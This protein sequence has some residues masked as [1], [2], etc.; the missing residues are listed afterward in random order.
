M[1]GGQFLPRAEGLRRAGGRGEQEEDP[2]LRGFPD[3]SSSSRRAPGSRPRLRGEGGGERARRRG[4]P[5]CCRDWSGGGPRWS[6][7]G[8]GEGGAR[9]RARGCAPR[10]PAP[11]PRGLRPPHTGVWSR[12][13]RRVAAPGTWRPTHCTPPLSV[14]NVLIPP[15]CSPPSPPPCRR[16][17]PPSLPSSKR[18]RAG[19]AGPGWSSG[20]GRQ[21]RACS[22]GPTEARGREGGDGSAALRRRRSRARDGGGAGSPATPQHLL[23][24]ALLPAA[25]ARAPGAGRRGRQERLPAAVPR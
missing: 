20:G 23:L 14:W 18:G 9:A 4:P 21:S 12:S 3:A 25:V 22:E 5:G 7:R 2:L 11:H 24:L 8:A 16:E 15:L 6:R 17:A 13:R 1:S 19:R 10:A